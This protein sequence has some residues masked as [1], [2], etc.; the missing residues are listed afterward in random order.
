MPKAV[1]F[2]GFPTQRIIMQFYGPVDAVC[3]EQ[4]LL[5]R[6]NLPNLDVRLKGKLQWLSCLLQYLCM[7]QGGPRPSPMPL[8]RY[9]RRHELAHQARMQARGSQSIPSITPSSLQTQNVIS[10]QA[11]HMS[12]LRKA[13]A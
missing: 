11:L 2:V 9:R 12:G 6:G 13:Q 1:H 4:H 3:R 8:E 10:D 5:E 7:R